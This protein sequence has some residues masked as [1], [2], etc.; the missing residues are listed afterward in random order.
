MKRTRL[1]VSIKNF[2]TFNSSWPWNQESIVGYIGEIVVDILSSNA[3]IFLY[4]QLSLLFISICIHFF[5]FNEMFARFVRE[6]DD[7]TDETSKTESIQKLIEFHL[8][9]KR[10]ENETN[11]QLF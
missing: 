3:F 7:S 8:K 2:I 11:S 9:I 6:L 5:A 10:C 1:N 4:G